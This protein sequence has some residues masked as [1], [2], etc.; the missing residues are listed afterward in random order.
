MFYDCRFLHMLLIQYFDGVDSEPVRWN[1]SIFANSL[2]YSVSTEAI[3]PCPFGAI[4]FS[5]KGFGV[6]W[7]ARGACV[8]ACGMF[9]LSGV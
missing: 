2:E 7:T 5:Q 1:S 4:F 6:N 3:V 8:K 9:R